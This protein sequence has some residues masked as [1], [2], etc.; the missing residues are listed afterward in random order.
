MAGAIHFRE[1]QGMASST[2]IGGSLP[3]P[4]LAPD[5]VGVQ[6]L[7][8]QEG[9]ERRARRLT[10]C[11]STRHRPPWRVRP[12]PEPLWSHPRRAGCGQGLSVA[13]ELEEQRSQRAWSRLRRPGAEP[14]A[15]AIAHAPTLVPTISSA[16]NER[17][18]VPR[19][20]A[21][22]QAF[23]TNGTRSSWTVAR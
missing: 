17:A 12:T 19:T 5:H 16:T 9:F 15:P 4:G 18:T 6:P 23:P 11:G 22:N 3:D 10:G 21:R 14:S 20:P 7:V 2:H 1:G 13:D 8:E